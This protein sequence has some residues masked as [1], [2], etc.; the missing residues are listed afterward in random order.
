MTVGLLDSPDRSVLKRKLHPRSNISDPLD[1]IPQ[2]AI[3]KKKA[4][5]MNIHKDA[6]M[7]PK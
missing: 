3:D 6:L 4:E 7:I 5:L 2:A 1:S